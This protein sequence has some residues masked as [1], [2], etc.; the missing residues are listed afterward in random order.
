MMTPVTLTATTVFFYLCSVV[1]YFVFL[2]VQRNRFYRAGY[3]LLL[4][5]V[6]V[7]TVLLGINISAR[8]HLPVFN[9]AQTLFVVSW[10]L[11]GAFLLLHHR[12]RLNFFGIYVAPLVLLVFLAAILLPEAANEQIPGL[13]RLANNGWLVAHIVT[14]FIGFAAL[15]MAAGLGGFYLI[16]ERAIKQKKH[17]FFYRRLPPLQLLDNAGYACLVTGFTMLT[18]GLVTGIVYAGLAWGRFWAWD[19][20]EVWSGVTWLVY[21]ALLHQRLA[22]GWQGRRAAIMAILGFGVLLFTFLGVNFLLEGHH[23][24]FTRV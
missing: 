5:G 20:K 10:A 21:A 19:P 13:K 15:A 14:V 17:G 11:G 4:A 8:G 18:V 9:L 7:H 24:V 16:Q 3:Y 6:F 12:L 1:A 22:V 2:A 23:G